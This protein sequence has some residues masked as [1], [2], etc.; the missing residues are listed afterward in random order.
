M[1]KRL[2]H[3]ILFV[4]TQNAIRSPMAAA[5]M[6]AAHGHRVYVASAGIEAGDPD[7]FVGLVMDEIGLDLTRH[8]P[9]AI[10]DLAD[11]AFDL[12]VTLSPEARA[13]AEEMAKTLAIEVEHWPTPDPSKEQ[14]SRNQIMDS[15]RAVRD[16]LAKNVRERFG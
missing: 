5:I 3:A 8:R 9:H 10:D 15:Y 14:G 7:P 11:H 13:H 16:G 4:C 2:P 1:D 6:H 12:V